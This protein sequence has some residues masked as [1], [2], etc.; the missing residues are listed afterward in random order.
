ML[1]R[2]SAGA[3]VLF[4][5]APVLARPATPAD[6]AAMQ[7]HHA[8]M[9]SD[10]YAEQVGETAFLEARLGLDGSQKRLFERWKAVTLARAKVRAAECAA[11]TPPDRPPSLIDRLTMEETMLTRRLDDLRAEMPA[12]KALF[13]SLSDEQKQAFRGPMAPRRGLRPPE[14]PPGPADDG[15]MRPGIPRPGTPDTD[16]T[17]P[18]A[19]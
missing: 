5:A 13:R 7:K 10:R 8:E 11:R 18:P 9:C 16:G 2:I 19:P 4:C 6:R 15:F 12:L 1:R 17:P 3:A 14:P